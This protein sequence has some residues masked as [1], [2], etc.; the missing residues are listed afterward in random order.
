MFC[1]N[2]LFEIW[3]FK[4]YNIYCKFGILSVLE[5]IGDKEACCYKSLSCL[6]CQILTQGVGGELILSKHRTGIVC[7]LTGY[8]EPGHKYPSLSYGPGNVS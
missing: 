7:M 5:E 6:L 3:I 8:A 4:S 2:V 1:I